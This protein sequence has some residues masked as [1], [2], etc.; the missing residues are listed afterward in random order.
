VVAYRNVYA[1]GGISRQSSFLETAEVVVSTCIY[2]PARNT[3]HTIVDVLEAIPI[4]LTQ[5]GTEVL[6]VDNASSD[7]TVARVRERLARGFPFP[8]TIQQNT[9]NRG[10]GGS[11]KL[12]YRQALERGHDIV[13]MLHGDGQYP[14][15]RVPALI[16]RLQEQPHA[17]MVYGSRLCLTEEV[18]ETP[19]VR[20]LGI[21][22]LS[23]LQNWVTGVRLAEWFSGFRAFRTQALQQIPFHACTDDYYFDVEIIL[24]L[25]LAGFTI[26]EAPVAK[27][28]REESSKPGGCRFALKVLTRM[29]RYPLARSGLVSTLLYQ[30]D[31]WQ[32]LKRVA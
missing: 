5:S 26:L 20:L 4:S 29:L 12:A 2:I 19:W 3:S 18:D 24:L 30:R 13:V 7:D 28:Y 8:V 27:R 21:R 6:V 1:K 31:R 11:Q 22:T 23:R 15:T 32:H 16:Q 17:G 10:Y 14:A 25:H 9:E